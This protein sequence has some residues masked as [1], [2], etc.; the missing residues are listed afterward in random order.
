MRRTTSRESSREY[1]RLLHSLSRGF[2]LIE[3]MVVILLVGLMAASTS[4]IVS[5][6]MDQSRLNEAVDRIILADQKERS[7]VRRSPIPGG[8]QFDR[9]G[10]LLRFQSSDQTVRLG[11]SIR[12]ADAIVS[13]GPQG[14]GDVQYSQSGQSVTFAIRLQSTQGASKWV[15]FIGATGQALVRA[16]SNDIRRIMALGAS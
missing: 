9:G 4:L 1:R 14:W 3:L 8:M 5:G 2:T 12:V 15:L 11:R 6:Q 10:G 13:G 7:E 16:D